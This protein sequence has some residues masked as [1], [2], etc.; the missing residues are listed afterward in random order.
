VN[1]RAC[2]RCGAQNPA[3]AAFCWQCFASFAGEAPA[4][5]VRAGKIGPAAYG[6][7]GGVMAPPAPAPMSTTTSST[8]WTRW[9][10]KGVLFL[11]GFA[12]GWWAVDHFF[13]SGFPFPDEIAGQ[14]RAESDATRDAAEAFSEIAEIFNVEMEM[15]LYGSEIQ[16]TYIMF[17]FE[18][19]EELPL[20][21]APGLSQTGTGEIPFQ[22]APDSTGAACVW[23]LDGSM[24]GL[25]AFGQTVEQLDPVARQVQAE[26]QS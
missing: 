8:G 12:A 22:C 10:I 23:G 14:P 26:L 21:G 4:G 5:P 3:A 11:V 7:T 24:V 13:F 15:A 2:A 16:P 9:V 25:G 20:G 18:V 19:P 6:G 17:A 1:E